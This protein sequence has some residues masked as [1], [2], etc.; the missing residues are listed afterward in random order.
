MS[1]T[2][3]VVGLTLSLVVPLAA[4][5]QLAPPEG[6]DPQTRYQIRQYE[7]AVRTAVL[8]AGEQLATRASTLVPGVLLAPAT[9]PQVRFVP[10][11]EGPVFDVVIPLLL[12]TGPVLMRMIQSQQQ[13][14]QVRPVAQNSDRVTGA[15]VVP[16]DPMTKSP[17]QDQDFDPNKEYTA[18]ARE[19]LIDVL[20]DNSSAV[21]LKEGERLE[22]AASGLEMIRGALYPD[23]SRKL[24]LV[25]TAAD[26]SAFRQGKITRDEAKARIKEA[27]Y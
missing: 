27:R 21:P 8:H 24:V 9:D 2:G 22:I 20:L 5:Q 1:S 15:G 25:I 13:Q 26:L 6:L 3:V 7:Q 23:N 12:D 4:Q 10:T 19:A 18:F 16:A 17:V 14:Q 11:P